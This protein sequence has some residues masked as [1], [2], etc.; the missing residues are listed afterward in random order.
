MPPRSVLLP[1]SDRSTAYGADWL[2]ADRLAAG[3]NALSL[4]GVIFRPVH[5]RPYYSVFRDVMV[6]GV[7]IHLTDVARAPLPLIQFYILQEINVLHP[8][9]NVFE[10]CDPSRLDMFDRVVGT[11]RVRLRFAERFRVEDIIELWTGGAESFAEK[12][13]RYFLY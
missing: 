7:Q 5:Y 9:K 13:A 2:E 12:A 1:F 4:P 8:D 6:H 3:L 10:L 11:D